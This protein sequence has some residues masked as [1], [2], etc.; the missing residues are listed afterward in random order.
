MSS[1]HYEAVTGMMSDPSICSVIFAPSPQNSTL[2]AITTK[3]RLT[4]AMVADP[5]DFVKRRMVENVRRAAPEV[6]GVLAEYLRDYLEKWFTVTTL[7]LPSRAPRMQVEAV[8]GRNFPFASHFN[9]L[10]LPEVEGVFFDPDD[11]V[12]L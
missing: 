7:N 1:G 11:F 4:E 10:S 12:D 5:D 3:V 2:T 8:P 6:R 9:I